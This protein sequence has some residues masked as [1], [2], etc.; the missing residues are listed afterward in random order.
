MNW[1]GWWF[2]FGYVDID[3]IILNTLS[4]S[5]VNVTW[6]F[7]LYFMAYKGLFTCNLINGAEFERLHW[8]D[9]IGRDYVVSLKWGLYVRMGNNWLCTGIFAICYFSWILFGDFLLETL[10][11]LVISHRWADCV[12]IW[13]VIFTDI[14][15]TLLFSTVRIRIV[16]TLLLDCVNLLFVSVSLLL[17][18]VSLLLVCV[19]LLFVC[20]T[21]LINLSL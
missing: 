17:V 1:V 10:A 14:A 6:D 19:S 21:K 8:Q 16:V 12:R 4:D 15:V 7:S 5:M 2:W 13:P 18:S 3:F 9:G 11:D 20:Q